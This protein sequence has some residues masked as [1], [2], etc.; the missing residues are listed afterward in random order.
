MNNFEKMVFQS[1]LQVCAHNHEERIP[2]FEQLRALIQMLEQHL[3]EV[4]AGVR[5]HAV[6]AEWQQ[7]YNDPDAP[8]D[9][10]VKATDDL[11]SVVAKQLGYANYKI[12]GQ[13]GWNIGVTY[14]GVDGMGWGVVQL[15]KDY[16][17]KT[18]PFK[19]GSFS[20]IQALKYAFKLQ[21]ALSRD[22]VYWAGEQP[23]K[24]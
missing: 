16:T 18:R 5:D 11:F 23:G 3:S 15:E 6:Y 4:A 14:A 9:K 19:K 20:P 22:F 7:I 21:W 8:N 10:L 24:W 1:L 2:Y 13:H 17:L 12:T